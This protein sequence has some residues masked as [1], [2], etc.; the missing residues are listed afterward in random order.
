MKRIIYLSFTFLL[1]TFF[2]LNAAIDW[3]GNRT[4]DSGTSPVSTSYPIS[5]EVFKSGA[6]N[7][8]GQ[9]FGIDCE[10][11]YGQV[12]SF[13][14]TWSNITSLFMSYDG[15]V[16]N[17]DKYVGSLN[18]AIGLY[19]YKC[20]CTDDDGANWTWD[21]E[22]NA[23][24]T[25]E[26]PVP[27]ALSYFNASVVGNEV[28]VEWIT[29]SEVN[30]NYFILEQST[31]LRTWKALAKIETQGN[32]FAQKEYNKLD[33]E[34]TSGINY[35]RLLQVDFDGKATYS[36]VVSARIDEIELNIYPNPTTQWLNI[37][38]KKEFSGTI[39]FYNAQGVLAKSLFIRNEYQV[40]LNLSE[41][42]NGIYFLKM[43]DIDGKELK[44]QRLMKK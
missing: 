2:K 1:F 8:A 37:D 26:A 24:L 13:G 40:H 36:K 5:V 32:S 38:L 28:L 9:S 42:A 35:Y 19:E 11:Y 6:T 18:L 30:N 21:D 25:V 12:A 7:P 31:D 22:A 17:N 3:V 33:E 16:N 15:D 29:Q 27:V 39:T 34:P 10:I 43:T 23:T 20:R 4:P 41:L 14:G 44:S